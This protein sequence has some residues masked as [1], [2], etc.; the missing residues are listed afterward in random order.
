[1]NTGKCYSDGS[2][3]QVGDTIMDENGCSA[4]VFEYKGKYRVATREGDLHNG[5][6]TTLG[7]FIIGGVTKVNNGTEAV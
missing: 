3:I 7:F 6:S 2:P 4:I 1:M 5:M